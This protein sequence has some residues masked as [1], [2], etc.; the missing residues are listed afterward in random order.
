[1]KLFQVFYAPEELFAGVG[2]TASWRLP[3]IAYILVTLVITFANTSLVDQGSVLRAQLEPSPR[4]AEQLGQERIDQMAREANAPAA[5]I[6]TCIIAPISSAVV[7]LI[8][9][10]VF[11]G[12]AQITSAGTTYKKI[13]GVTAYS[14]FAYG[15][16]AGAGGLIVLLIMGDPSGAEMTNLIKLNPTLFMDRASTSKALYSIASSLDL[17]SFWMIFLLGLGIS[18]VSAGMSLTKG[19]IIVI[20]PWIVYV[21]GKAGVATLF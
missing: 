10:G 7:A 1:M 14:L 20:I 19:L 5:R 15:L 21:L 9:A 8:V 17:L 12:L 2:K 3:F 16:V 13:L 18:K 4:I 6:R 11:F